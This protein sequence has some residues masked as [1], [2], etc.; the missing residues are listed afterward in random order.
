M[1]YAYILMCSDGT[2]YSGWTNDLARR[3]RT[4]NAG[5]GAK[6]TRVRRPVELVYYEEFEEKTEAQRRECAFKKLS[7]RAKE[8]LAAKA[9]LTPPE[10]ERNISGKSS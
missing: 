1:N 3:L 6:Y 9:P 7:H 10:T 2:Y 5:R 4:H 8:A